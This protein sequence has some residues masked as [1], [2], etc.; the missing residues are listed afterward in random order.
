MLKKNMSSLERRCRD[1]RAQVQV[2]KMNLDSAKSSLAEGMP[3][4]PLLT[5]KSDRNNKKRVLKSTGVSKLQNRIAHGL[6]A[7]QDI[8]DCE[9]A[10]IV[11]DEW[12]ITVETHFENLRSKVDDMEGTLSD[13]QDCSLLLEAK[14]RD[15][16]A[17]EENPAAAPVEND[18]A[19]LCLR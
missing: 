14:L 2:S 8:L 17:A 13:E 18:Q 6:N 19:E 12:T 7:A 16:V 10:G 9:R 4:R 1:K 3:L 15:E 5:Q 11:R